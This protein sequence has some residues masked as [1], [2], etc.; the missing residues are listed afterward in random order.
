M[1]TTSKWINIKEKKPANSE[2]CYFTDG[3]SVIIG[4]WYSCLMI[5]KGREITPTKWAPMDGPEP[6]VK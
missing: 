4:I 5:L 6:K 2:F 3:K 1:K